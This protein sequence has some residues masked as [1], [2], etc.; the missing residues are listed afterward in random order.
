[1]NTIIN[2]I[3][4]IYNEEIESFCTRLL[5]F[6]NTI[7]TYSI[8]AGITAFILVTNEKVFLSAFIIALI[9]SW[10]TCKIADFY[11]VFILFAT[12][13]MIGIGWIIGIKGDLIIN[14]LTASIIILLVIQFV[15]MGIPD[16]IVS[17]DPK[18]GILKIFNSLITIAPTTVSFSMSLFFSFYVSYIAILSQ[19][20][21]Y[22]NN[23]Y[24]LAI[25]SILLI[26][27][28][29]LTRI[30][31]PK[32][33]FTK[34]HK[35]DMLDTPMFKRVVVLNVDGARKDIFD[36]LDMPAIK[37][38]RDEGADHVK[39]LE[40]VY[41]ALTNP[42]FASILTGTIPKIHGIR[43]NNLGQSIQTEG[44]ADIVPTI[45]YG[46]MHVKHFSKKYWNT[47]IVSLP[48]HSVYKSDDI[49]VQWLKDDIERQGDVRLFVADFSEADFLA[50]AYGSKSKAYKD[51]LI[52]IDK[53]I[54]DIKEWLS[55]KGLLDDTCIIICSDHGIAAID[56]SYLIARSER[57]VPFIMSGKGIKKGY[58]ING[59][60]KIMDICCTIA[61]LLGIRYP[62]DARGSVFVEAIENID[63]E[64]QQEEF[65]NRFN[66][67]K[68]DI[69]A[70]EY[71]SHTEVIQGDRDWWDGCCNKY[72]KAYKT[73][74][75]ILDIG[76]GNGFVASRFIA[77]KVAFREF[78]CFD[79]SVEIL[80]EAKRNLHG[81]ENIVYIDDM[82]SK[83][84]KFDII[85]VS[86]V[87]HHNVDTQKM[88]IKIK[89]LL[90]DGGMIIG[91]H[92]P[93]RKAFENPLFRAAATFYKSIGG[94]ISISKP[95]VEEFNRVL[96]EL[97]P[98]APSVCREEILQMVEYHSPLEQYDKGV[99]RNAG[100]YVK[101]FF[102]SH[103]PNFVIMECET[104]S[105]FY[106]RDW[107]NRH[108][109][110]QIALK[111][112]YNIVFSEGNLFRY[113][114]KGRD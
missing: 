27:S 52:R 11:P 78:V 97:Y 39:G 114:L 86:S 68:Y 65:C 46:S 79:I 22:N 104:Y 63:R 76:C 33:R 98:K 83:I 34:F 16:S 28:A 6:F 41:R 35:P 24:W 56:H 1:M 48:R 44:L 88:A 10:L 112:M 21:I 45:S 71:S 105:T 82:D 89:S 101:E 113:V 15:F 18:V 81:V 109:V 106:H 107:L 100:F 75:R 54:G 14:L 17:R 94:G 57:Y 110:V 25:T 40:T 80:L 5:Y 13:I 26:L 58:K 8:F 2:I 66:K 30:F 42:A 43:D 49:M 31:L 62:M 95:I 9:L 60:G 36:S 59:D 90:A 38:L 93:N 103:F 111:K 74:P 96:K 87:F 7:N 61:Y 99:D 37:R 32:N 72:F 29:C 108:K 77:N 67:I 84:G 12:P 102:A 85:T 73:P 23:I 92:E 4:K 3:S 51:A 47:K 69:E 91:S 64:T 19:S 50:H 53:R 70:K 20:Y 55:D